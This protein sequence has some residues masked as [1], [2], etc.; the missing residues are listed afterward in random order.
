[1]DDKFISFDKSTGILSCEGGTT[2]DEILRPNGTCGWFV[3]TT[4]G[5]RF[6][7]V[8]GAIANDV[9][10]RTITVRERLAVTFVRFELR[11]SDGETLLC[12]T[13]KTPNCFMRPSGLGLPA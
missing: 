2:L 3:P 1:M 6:V 9:H 12:S 4:P 7:T 10:A 11:R 13:R 5:I 8:G